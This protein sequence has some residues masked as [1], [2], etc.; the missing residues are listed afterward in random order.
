MD[1]IVER[2]LAMAGEGAMTDQVTQLLAVD[3]I[4]LLRER[5]Q[6]YLDRCAERE[7]RVEVVGAD[8]IERT[9]VRKA[10]RRSRRRW[11]RSRSSAC[12]IR[13][14]R[15]RDRSARRRAGAAG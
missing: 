4:A 15:R 8:G 11:A 9:E 13:P 6:G 12:S 3:G 1:K 14:W 2:L 5:L 7:R 10:S